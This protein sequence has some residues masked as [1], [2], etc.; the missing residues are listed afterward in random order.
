[1]TD[2]PTTVGELRRLLADLPDDAP[3]WLDIWTPPQVQALLADWLATYEPED[4][5][6]IDVHDFRVIRSVMDLLPSPVWMQ[7]EDHAVEV[8]FDRLDDAFGGA[9]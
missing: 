5:P 3:V 6:R 1:M 9:A 4:R 7:D 8:F 2:N